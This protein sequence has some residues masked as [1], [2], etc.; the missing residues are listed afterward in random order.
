[1]ILIYLPRE[2]DPPEDDPP[3]PPLLLL[4]LLPEE[5]ELLPEE[6]LLLPL[7]RDGEYDPPEF[8]LLPELP[9]LRD[10]V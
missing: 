8:P 4:E 2:R 3:P 5:L 9:L 1:M 10:G 6:E 7:L